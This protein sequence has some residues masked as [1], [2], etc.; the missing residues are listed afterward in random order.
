VRKTI[1]V[2][3]SGTLFEQHSLETLMVLGVDRAAAL[4]ALSKAHRLACQQLH[5]IVGVRRHLAPPFSQRGRHAAQRP[6]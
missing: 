4:K 5:S 1:L 3:H 2:G 6:P